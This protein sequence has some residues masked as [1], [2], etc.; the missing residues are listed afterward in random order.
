M[1]YT[2]K[3]VRPN[4][5][6]AVWVER[7]DGSKAVVETFKNRTAAKTLA[8]RLNIGRVEMAKF[9]PDRDLRS[10]GTPS[11][12]LLRELEAKQQEERE[13]FEKNKFAILAGIRQQE[14]L[15]ALPVVMH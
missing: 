7:R 15:D 8:Y 10:T 14:K 5:P 3:R 9:D 2:I 12:Q 13:N 11:K 4:G 1:K 6:W